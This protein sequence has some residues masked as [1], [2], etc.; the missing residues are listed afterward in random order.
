M[1]THSVILSAA[2]DLLDCEE[3]LHCVQDDGKEVQDDGKEVQDDGKEVQD[4][5]DR[6]L[7]LPK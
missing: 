6:G 4:D 2:K 3:I 1:T 7:V 5:G